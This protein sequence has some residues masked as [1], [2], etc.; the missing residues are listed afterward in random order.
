MVVTSEALW[1][2]LVAFHS[3]YVTILDCAIARYW[4]KIADLNLPHLYLVS[5]LGVIP[6]DIL[7]RLLASEI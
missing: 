1:F 4:L 3:N 6:L 2:I 5:P 7:L